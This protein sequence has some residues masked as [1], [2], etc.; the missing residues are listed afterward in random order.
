M[1][2]PMHP[3]Q[4]HY[5]SSPSSSSMYS[6]WTRANALFFTALSALAVL[7]ALTTLSTYTH[8]AYPEVRVLRLLKVHSL[9]NYRDKTDRA[10]L[11]FDLDAGASDCLSCPAVGYS[12]CASCLVRPQI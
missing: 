11:T 6:V 12:S 9:R 8:V 10:T 7:C 1:W 3:Q 2:Y 4:L 5:V